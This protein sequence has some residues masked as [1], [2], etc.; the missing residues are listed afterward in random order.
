MITLVFNYSLSPWTGPK[1][2]HELMGRQ[3]EELLKY[4]PDYPLYVIDPMRMKASDLALMKTELGCICKCFK[5]CKDRSRL[6]K[7]IKS[8]GRFKAL[9]KTAAKLLNQRL[10][11]GVKIDNDKQKEKCNMCQAIEEMKAIAEKRGEKRGVKL[12][13]KNARLII[14]QNLLRQTDMTIK[15]IAASTELTQREIKAIAAELNKETA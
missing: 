8:D 13:D 5:Y 3:P 7:M 6:K 10:N 12:G 2:L 11:L 9:S 4:V 14:A 15:A 1:S